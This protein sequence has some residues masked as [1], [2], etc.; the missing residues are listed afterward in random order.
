[1]LE[2]SKF[3]IDRRNLDLALAFQLVA[4][5]EERRDLRERNA[6]KMRQEGFDRRNVPPPTPLI[7][8]RILFNVNL[9]KLFKEDSI[10][11]SKVILAA[12]DICLDRG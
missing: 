8:F 3:T 1:M 12:E 4:F 9:S 5:Y 11:G 6:P 10:L 7:G 2:E